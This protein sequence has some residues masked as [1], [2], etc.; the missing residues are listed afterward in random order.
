MDF[1]I[2]PVHIPADTEPPR[3]LPLTALE[4]DAVLHAVY[5]WQTK[6]QPVPVHKTLP[7]ASERAL[8]KGYL[9]RSRLP[10]IGPQGG[11]YRA[12][13][14]TA[15]GI[16]FYHQYKAQEERNTAMQYFFTEIHDG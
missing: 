4:R 16:A 13:F 14:P 6:G 15:K 9:L 2:P 10:W 1:Y 8:T 5:W 12:F 11:Q 7:G 3:I